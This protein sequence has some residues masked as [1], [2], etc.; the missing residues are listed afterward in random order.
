MSPVT[1]FTLNELQRLVPSFR[2]EAVASENKAVQKAI[3]D[4]FFR[5]GCNT[6]EGI[7][8]QYDCVSKNKFGELDDSPRFIVAERL[9]NDWLMSG[10]ASTAAKQYTSDTSLVVDLWKLR[11]KG[12]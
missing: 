8:V 2:A 7:E 12:N 11:N 3:T 5:L 4:M 1:V 10:Y 6:E 9:D